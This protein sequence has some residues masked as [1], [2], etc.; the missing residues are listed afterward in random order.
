MFEMAFPVLAWLFGKQQGNEI[1]FQVVN[2]VSGQILHTYINPWLDG[3]VSVYWSPIDKDYII[4][5]T[6]NRMVLSIK[7]TDYPDLSQEG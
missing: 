5:A 7:I 1:V 2:I 6:D 3:L 4:L